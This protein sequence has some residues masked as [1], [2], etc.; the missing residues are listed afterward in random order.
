MVLDWWFVVSK[1]TVLMLKL[2]LTVML[3]CRVSC[4]VYPYGPP[5]MRCSL[6]S[7][8]EEFSD[9]TKFCHDG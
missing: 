8:K 7:I 9:K 5:M 1:K 3:E 6:L 4:L 2:S